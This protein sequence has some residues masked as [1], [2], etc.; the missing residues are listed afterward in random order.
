MPPGLHRSLSESLE[1]LDPAVKKKPETHTL[2]IDAIIAML[3][4]EWDLRIPL[5]RGNDSP[6]QRQEKG[7]NTE[8]Q[9][10]VR[11]K[12]LQYQDKDKLSKA[13]GLFDDEA[14]LLYQGWVHK[15]HQERGVLPPRTR[16]VTH[17]VS[18]MERKEL[19][20]C[21]LRILDEPY[22]EYRFTPSSSRKREPR[23][24]FDDTPIASPSLLRSVKRTSND[25]FDDVSIK[26]QKQP[27]EQM[28]PPRTRRQTE[29]H[30]ETS[31]VSHASTVFSHAPSL[32]NFQTQST[33]PDEESEIATEPNS[34]VHGPQSSDYGSS[35]FDQHVKDSS[36]A[37]HTFDDAKILLKEDDAPG[38]LSFEIAKSNRALKDLC[39]SLQNLFRRLSLNL[40]CV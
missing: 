24:M 2:E 30:A 36:N 18:D 34:P 11:I 37:G 38:L 29:L 23:R 12:F 21:L 15:P 4:Q 10:L 8:V 32:K 28:A 3:N 17:P 31:F 7:W 1:F 26:K 40:R 33:L 16:H 19:L 14:Q 22:Q 35:S 27:T 20:A 5:S 6:R 9:C 13:K 39:A 25:H